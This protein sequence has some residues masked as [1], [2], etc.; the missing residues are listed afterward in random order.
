VN[1]PAGAT[2]AVE[3]LGCKVSLCDAQAVRERL[4]AGGHREVEGAADVRVVN[5][6]CVTAEAV[7]KSRKAVRRAARS[8]GRVVV[9]GCAANLDPAALG[10]LPATVTV[11]RERSERTP[12]LV[13]DW[14]G[15]LGCAGGGPPAFAR[16]RAYL[17]IQD[18]CSFGCSYCVI[19]LVRGESRSRTA[20]A[21]LAEAARRAGQGHRE[22]VLT[23]INLGCFRDRAAGV[24]LADL[25]ER[26]AQ[27]PGIERVRLSSIE[28]NHLGP[29]LLDAM[30][31]TPAIAPHLHVP[32]Q[33]GS[34]RVLR[35]M[36]R[37]Y[38]VE[39]FLARIDRARD[40]VPGLNLTTDVIVGHP[41]EDDDA[42][43]E[44]L[45]LVERAGFSNVH[46]F[47]YS[48]RPGTADADRDRHPP[49][50]RRSRVDR[51]LE[52]SE[53]LGT[54]R[55]QALLGSRAQV[56]VETAAGTGRAADY[57]AFVVPGGTP[58]RMHE[59]VATAV[60]GACLVGEAA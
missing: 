36:R 44:T 13:S 12:Q 58:G 15:G 22:L 18:G 32:L 2:F 57:T 10:P 39:T 9:T 60:R 29:R 49:A 59:V 28:V 3:F 50:V 21:V 35:A 31:G 1:D 24:G 23:G 33:S 52:L 7:A 5:T 17:R 48:P 8:A 41:A 16:T 54:A 56:L 14:V 38:T 53:R 45:A 4:I 25:L 11:V 55:R 27:V 40:R 51:L 46:V 26:C 34:G 6:C 20:A 42:F 19:P 43:A 47:P 37:H 30:A